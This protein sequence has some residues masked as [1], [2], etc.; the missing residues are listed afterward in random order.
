MNTDRLAFLENLAAKSAELGTIFLNHSGAP[1]NMLTGISSIELL[2]DKS[3]QHAFLNFCLQHPL[4]KDL[5]IIPKF[6]RTEIIVELEDRSE[7]KF[8][9]IRSVIRRSLNCLDIA[10][11]KKEAFVNE[12]GMLVASAK[13]QF[14]YLVLVNQYAQHPM[15]D[16]FKNYF[17]AFD[18]NVR[19]TI[20]RYVQ[21]KYD[22]VLNT[23]DELYK[24]STSYLLKINSGLRLQK[25]N[26]L[27]KMIL[28]VVEYTIFNAAGSITKKP[29]HLS[30]TLR[31]KA[32]GAAK[33]P[34]NTTGQAML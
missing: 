7:L 23:L 14:N 32:R 2:A 15:P 29:K 21:P 13:H 3:V 19:T 11:I 18:K 12:F 33:K 22:L 31:D 28:R 8:N 30:P 16:R 17:S 27:F 20:F 26:S 10:E 4:V 1:S 24:P 5:T 9:L 25:T 34:G 6:R